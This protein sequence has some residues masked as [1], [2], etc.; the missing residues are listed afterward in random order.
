MAKEM[1]GWELRGY[2]A[3]PN[4]FGKPKP[5]TIEENRFCRGWSKAQAEANLERTSDYHMHLAQEAE[6]GR[7][8]YSANY[9]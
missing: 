8:S 4:H 3:Y 2:L 6:L 5:G 7:D 9:F 1:T